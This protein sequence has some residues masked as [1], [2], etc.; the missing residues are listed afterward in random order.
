MVNSIIW[1]KTSH[2]RFEPVRHNFTYPVMM[3]NLDLFSL[4][5]TQLPSFFSYNSP[6]L[7]SLWDKDYLNLTNDS[8][9]DKILKLLDRFNY[10]KTTASIQLTTIPRHVFKS[11]KPVSFYSCF[12]DQSELIGAIIE[13]SNTYHETHFYALENHQKDNLKTSLKFK[14]DKTF[15]VSPFFEEEGCYRFEMFQSETFIDFKIRI[16]IIRFFVPCQT[17]DFETGL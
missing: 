14:V 3:V 15:H 8:L 17:N 5:Q 9:K 13:V 4:A 2:H 16:P 11:F 10:L 1:G 6:G 7:Y 12:N